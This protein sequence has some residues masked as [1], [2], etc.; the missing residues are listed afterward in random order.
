[1]KDFA[2][3]IENTQKQLLIFSGNL[4]FTNLKTE[5]KDFSQIFDTLI[6]RDVSI[7]VISRI[8]IA[9]RDNIEQVLALNHKH[10]KECIEIHHREQPLRAII[11]DNKIFRIKEIKLP[12]GKE[13]E[14]E[15]KLF[16]YYTISDPEWINWITKIFWKMFSA[17]IDANKR[18]TEIKKL[19]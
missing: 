10:G 14:L 4:S 16:I 8:D 11:S 15:K 5:N 18:I 17:S 9:G 13:H 2:E 1:M 6:K 19:K 12:T 7:K 3:I